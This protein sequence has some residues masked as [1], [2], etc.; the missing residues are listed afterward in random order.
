MPQVNPGSEDSVKVAVAG[1]GKDLRNRNVTVQ[2]TDGTF[3][4]VQQEV[5]TR[6]ADDGTILDTL[7]WVENN[8]Q[9]AMRGYMESLLDVMQAIA[10]QGGILPINDP[11]TVIPGE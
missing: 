9:R 6:A 7:G 1:S 11:P 2:Q 4:T 10:A 5:V 3:L 8:Y